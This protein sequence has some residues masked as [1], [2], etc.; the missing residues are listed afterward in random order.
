M[1]ISLENWARPLQVAGLTAA[2]LGYAGT[3]ASQPQ[4]NQL[5]A[6]STSSSG[7]PGAGSLEGSATTAGDNMTIAQI[8]ERGKAIVARIDS[9]EDQIAAMLETAQ[10]QRD[11]VRVLCLADK[12]NQ[13]GLA[14]G[15][16]KDRNASLLA[17][18]TRGSEARARHEYRLLA[19][20]SE[21][22]EFLVAEA[23]QCLGEEAG[24]VGDSTLVVNVDP[25]LPAPDPAAVATP[26]IAAVV[27]LV[28]SPV[29]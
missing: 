19:V 25:N 13:V 18:L 1:K 15:T 7:S 9:V 27:P 2:L 16:A 21:R 12:N 6:P 24:P 8:K 29:D 22:V 17:A 3:A 26:P 5:A 28:P 14:L 20:V 11:V 23:N 10:D 4:G